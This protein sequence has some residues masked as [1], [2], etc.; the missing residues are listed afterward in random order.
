M[1]KKYKKKRK[2]SSFM[3]TMINPSHLHPSQIKFFLIALPIAIVM[4]LPIIFIVSHS[5]KPLDELYAYPPKFFASRPT[6]DNF[7]N[8]FQVA[9]QSGVPLED[10]YLIVLFKQFL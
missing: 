7:R 4:L 5:F 2:K 10:I 6:F 9:S 1:G 8:L 3:G